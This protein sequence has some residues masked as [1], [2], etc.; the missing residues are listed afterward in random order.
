M[1]KCVCVCVCAST[2]FKYKMSIRTLYN[3]VKRKVE[4]EKIQ[5]LQIIN[6]IHI[7]CVRSSKNKISQIIKNIF[8]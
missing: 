2:L 4:E 8:F 5:Q 7:T 1:Y 6:R 3:I